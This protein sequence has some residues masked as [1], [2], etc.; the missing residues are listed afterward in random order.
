MF[1]SDTRG[2]LL[3]T[4]NTIHI[5]E[6]APW[7]I[8]LLRKIPIHIL[9]RVQPGKATIFKAMEAVYDQA[10]LSFNARPGHSSTQT[11]KHEKRTMFDNLVDPEVPAS[12]RIL[13]RLQEEGLVVLGAGTETEA[14]TLTISMFYLSKNQDVLRRLRTELKQVLLTPSSNASLLELEKLPSLVCV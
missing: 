1:R 4:A 10:V 13:D 6:F 5:G 2:A 7:L 11:E 9:R 3:E 8:M 12:E 14:H